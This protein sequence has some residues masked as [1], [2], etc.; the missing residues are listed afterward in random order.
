LRGYGEPLRLAWSGRHLPG[1]ALHLLLRA[2]S[3]VPSTTDWRLD[4]YG[5]GPSTITWQRLAARLRIGSRC[6]WHGQVSRVEA[7]AAF[8]TAHL[9]VTTSLK[10]LTS[11]VIL[12]ALAQGVPVLCPNHCGFP[13]VVDETCGMRLPIGTAAE[14]ERALAEAITK[15]AGDENMRR[16][17]AAG[18][19]ARAPQFSWEAKARAIDAVYRRVMGVIR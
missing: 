2:L 8:N 5:D 4:L 9:F 17:L 18:A 13:D 15:L 10:D 1:K 3:R 16:R 6:V 7:I 12:E 19:L 14:F 11:T